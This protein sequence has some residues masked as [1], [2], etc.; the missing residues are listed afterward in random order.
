MKKEA[1]TSYQSLFKLIVFRSFLSLV[2]L[3]LTSFDALV[4]IGFR[5]IPNVTKKYKNLKHFP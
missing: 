2:I 5:V 4:Q 1:G 3:Q